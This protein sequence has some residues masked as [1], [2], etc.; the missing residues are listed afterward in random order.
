MRWCGEGRGERAGDECPGA[1]VGRGCTSERK[2]TNTTNAGAQGRRH[3]IA[4]T[5]ESSVGGRARPAHTPLIRHRD[6]ARANDGSRVADLESPIPWVDA[7]RL[8][9]A[10]AC[11]V[12]AQRLPPRTPRAGVLYE[13]CMVSGVEGETRGGPG[14]TVARASGMAAAGPLKSVSFAAWTLLGAGGGSDTPVRLL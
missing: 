7:S 9:S 12:L 1:L 14:T 3:E 2:R 5:G 8:T 11:A 4:P 10:G 13:P 6:P